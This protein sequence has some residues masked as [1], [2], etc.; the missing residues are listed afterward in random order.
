MNQIELIKRAWRL[1]W[2]YKVLWIFGFLL[3]LTGSSGGGLGWSGNSRGFGARNFDGFNAVPGLRDFDPAKALRNVD[4]HAVIG[5][6]VLCCCL[7]LLFGIAA[8]IVNYVARAALYRMVDEIETA[9]AAPDWRTGLRLGWTNRT[10]RLF[11]L[12]LVVGISIA[13]GAVILAGVAVAPLL[14]LGGAGGG[15][16][17]LGIILTVVLGL[18][19]LVVILFAVLA[20]TLLGQFWAREIVLR[21]LRVGQALAAGYATVRHSLGS[22]ALL[23]I[24]LAGIGVGFGIVLIPVVLVLLLAAAAVGG[25]TG[26]ALYLASH[27]VA[28]AIVVGLPLFLIV[29]TL[30]L[31]AVRGVYESWSSGVWTLAFRELNAVPAPAGAVPPAAPA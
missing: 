17:V 29:L 25:G 23:W 6:V 18:I 16:R 3:A 1:T 10:F 20:L 5:L 22:L 24:I 9:G 11:L 26:Y 2:R 8:A 31:S 27:S 15:A 7:L 30:P 28:L 4:L 14:L 12:D 21:D 13:I 19:F